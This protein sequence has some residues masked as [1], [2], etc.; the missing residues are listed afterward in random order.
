MEIKGMIELGLIALAILG[1]LGLIANR[2]VTKKGIGDRAIQ[3][4][5]LCIVPTVTAILALE[6]L[7]S[8][9]VVQAIFAGVV[10]FVANE[11]IRRRGETS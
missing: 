10:G 8:S 6:R 4:L 5:G 11:V 2:V 7:V 1:T 3:W 9:E